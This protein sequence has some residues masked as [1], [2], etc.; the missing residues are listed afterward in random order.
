M[1]FEVCPSTARQ[2]R[3]YLNLFRL[4]ERESWASESV[5]QCD[6]AGKY[7]ST[8]ATQVI[9]QV[10]GTPSSTLTWGSKRGSLSQLRGFMGRRE[11]ITDPSD[12]KATLVQ[13]FQYLAYPDFPYHY[14]HCYLLCYHNHPFLQYL[15]SRS[16]IS[17]LCFA[18]GSESLAGP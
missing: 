12:A 11:N 5:L 17:P 10:L 2:W 4:P 3:M 13:F 18:L 14:I 1:F 6:V 7:H 15:F 8:S 9:A 16:L